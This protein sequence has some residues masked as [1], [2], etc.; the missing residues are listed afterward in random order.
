[1]IGNRD[2]V[3]KYFS[4]KNGKVVLSLGNNAPEVMDGV[5]KR[6]NK[7][8]VVV[9]E[10]VADFI[11]GKIQSMRIKPAPDDK[12][13]FKDQIQLT[14]T[15]EAGDTFSVEMPFDS[16]YGRGFL[17]AL[18]NV[19]PSDPIELEPYKFFD[20]KSGRDKMGV[21]VLQYGS[22]LDWT[23]GTKA[24]PGGVPNLKQIEFKGEKVWDNTDQLAFLEKF[25]LEKAAAIA[26][27]VP[28]PVSDD[29]RLH[30]EDDD[31]APF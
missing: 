19:V 4:I 28:E 20:K 23:M 30:P 31:E 1:M 25:F 8:G 2:R 7:D 16:A 21:Q 17:Y 26:E 3:R 14:M 13:N 11:R 9:Y 24:N 6:T 29:F 22:R 12:P 27:V 18:D 10:I 5:T 15:D